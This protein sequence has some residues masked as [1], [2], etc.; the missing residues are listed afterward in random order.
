MIPKEIPRYFEFISLGKCSPNA[1]SSFSFLQFDSLR[2][3]GWLRHLVNIDSYNLDKLGY[4]LLYL[5]SAL[6]EYRVPI[7]ILVKTPSTK[8]LVPS[9]H[10]Q[11]GR[12]YRPDPSFRSELWGF[13]FLPLGSIVLIKFVF[14]KHLRQFQPSFRTFTQLASV[15]LEIFSAGRTIFSPFVKFSFIIPVSYFDLVRPSCSNCT[16]PTISCNPPSCRE[17]VAS[18][19]TSIGQHPG[20]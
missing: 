1:L 14:S 13:S 19:A 16:A 17:V 6:C 12:N 8:L 7:D 11:L 2:I 10:I 9:T 15:L 18:H 20:Y 3:N 4:N 5:V